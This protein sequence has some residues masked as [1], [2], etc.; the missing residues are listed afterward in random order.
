VDATRF[1]DVY[2]EVVPESVVYGWNELGRSHQQAHGGRI[3]EGYL[4]ILNAGTKFG[5]DGD[6]GPV[7]ATSTASVVLSPAVRDTISFAEAALTSISQSKLVILSSLATFL[8][9]CLSVPSSASPKG[10]S[11][12][13]I[14]T[15][16][17]EPSFPTPQGLKSFEHLLRP[18]FNTRSSF[19][20]RVWDPQ[21]GRDEYKERPIDG[22][23]LARP[24]P[25]AVWTL[26]DLSVTGDL[27]ELVD[28]SEGSTERLLVSVR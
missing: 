12:S 20:V 16:Y 6:T 17:L 21:P 10:V 27:L 1:L 28:L 3:L 15:W 23:I 24:S 4:G 14:P 25:A 11:T 5:E 9:T 19:D 26:Q 22:F 13:F 7:S 18:T 8:H 2:L